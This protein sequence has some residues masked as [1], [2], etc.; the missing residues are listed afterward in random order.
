MLKI[1]D[2]THTD[3]NRDCLLVCVILYQPQNGYCCTTVIGAIISS[4]IQ[5]VT[6]SR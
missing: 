5:A 4:L 1:N 2:K 6:F 3:F